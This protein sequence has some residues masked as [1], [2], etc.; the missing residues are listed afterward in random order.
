M[1]RNTLTLLCGCSG[2]L[3]AASAISARATD[4]LTYG[5]NVQHTGENPF[6]TVLTP[7]TVRGLHQLWSFD[8]GAVTIMQP[9]LAQGVMV[10]GSP[11]DLVYMGAEHGDLYALEAATGTLVW[12]RNLGSQ[13]TRCS[14]IPDKISRS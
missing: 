3:L 2:L 5:F 14:D 12:Q 9:V 10:N 1:K 8:L 11:K 13:Q 6:E 7:A 4:W